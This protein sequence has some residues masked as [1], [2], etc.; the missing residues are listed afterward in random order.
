MCG[1]VVYVINLLPTHVAKQ[2]KESC[3]I[4]GWVLPIFGTLSFQDTLYY[5]SRT[6]YKRIRRIT[7]KYM[8]EIVTE[9]RFWTQLI[10][11]L[12]FVKYLLA[13]LQCNY[14]GKRLLLDQ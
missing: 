8:P 12:R 13:P 3:K 2:G 11:I 7:H 9:L 14:L 4:P 6:F 10:L 5:C 1:V